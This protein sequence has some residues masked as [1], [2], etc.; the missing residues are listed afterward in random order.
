M[1]K[2]G[3]THVDAIENARVQSIDLPTTEILAQM[4]EE[5]ADSPRQR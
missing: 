1:T 5:A 3:K 4:A 2:Y